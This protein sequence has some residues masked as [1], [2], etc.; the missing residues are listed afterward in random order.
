[1]ILDILVKAT[2]VLGLASLFSLAT[3][4]RAPSAVRHAAWVSALVGAALV[5][6]LWGVLPALRVPLMPARLQA[7]SLGVAGTANPPMSATAGDATGGLLANTSA[8]PTPPDEVVGRP[9]SPAALPDASPITGALDETWAM[10]RAA[11]SVIGAVPA[12]ALV[13]ALGTAILLGRLIAAR[14]SVARVTRTRVPGRAPWLPVARRLARVMR[15][16]RRLRFLRSDRVAMPMAFGVWRPAV[17]LPADA[18]QWSTDRLRAVLLHELG[19]V[20]RRDCLSQ[21]AANL[22]LALLWFHPLAWVARSAVRRERERACDD[23]VLAA[24]TP[25]PEYASHLLDV[26]RDARHRRTSLTLAGGVAMARPSELEGRLMA[27]LDDTQPRRALTARAFAAVGLITLGVVA[28][29]SAL[30]LW[31]SP[32]PVVAALPA[33]P[34]IARAVDAQ[35]PMPT[36]TATPVAARA[37]LTESFDGDTPTPARAPR[38]AQQPTSAAPAVAPAAPAPNATP[39]LAPTARQT[40]PVKGVPGG[41]KGGVPGGVG[42]RAAK[43]GKPSTPPIPVSSRR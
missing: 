16:P 12:I 11:R 38:L 20:R 26:A 25:A 40:A 34:A 32:G 22:A 10:W 1:M 30:D 18:D 15:V 7:M 5:P 31:Q 42:P 27:I 33:S 29:L 21:V 43:A 41:V 28:P 23:L 8:A 14:L 3:R 13:W 2:I 24:G 4:G 17:V 19:H 36:P 6:V 37:P 9:R 39:V 35:E